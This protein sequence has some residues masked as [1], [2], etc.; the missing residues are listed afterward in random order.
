MV[1]ITQLNPREYKNKDAAKKVIEYISRTRENED[2]YCELICFGDAAG[3]NHNKAPAQ[4]I[5]EFQFI[6]NTL[7]RKPGSRM[8]HFSIK[9][10][11]E[12]FR[13]LNN[14]FNRLADYAV[15]CCRYILN[16]GYRQESCIPAA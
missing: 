2:R 10:T 16:L 7:L 9:V 1:L 4:T 6:H 11:L 3:Y 5:A 14:D 8:M 15:D 13:R 12:D